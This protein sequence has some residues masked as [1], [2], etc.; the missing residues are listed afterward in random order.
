MSSASSADPSWHNLPLGDLSTELAE[1][2]F[3]A[4]RMAE[5][6]QSE[7]IEM[8]RSA[9]RSFSEREWRSALAMGISRKGASEESRF[10]AAVSAYRSAARGGVPHTTNVT[11][12]LIK[13]GTALVC[14]ARPVPK[15][16]ADGADWRRVE[17]A[18]KRTAWCNGVMRKE[19][20]HKKSLQA[21]QNGCTMGD[22]YLGVVRAF[23]EPDIKI[24]HWFTLDCVPDDE[25][26]CFYRVERVMHQRIARRYGD[27]RADQ[28]ECDDPDAV[29]PLV[30]G[31]FFNEKNADPDASCIGRYAVAAEGAPLLFEEY[32]H[33]GPP[34]VRWSWARDPVGLQ[35]C[36]IPW[37]VKGIQ[38]LINVID[39][40][41]HS[42]IWQGGQLRIFAHRL[43]KIDK[44]HISNSLRAQ[45]LEWSGDKPP[46]FAITP[47]VARDLTEFRQVL[48][49]AAYEMTGL[50]ISNA[51]ASPQ[52]AGESGRARLLEDKSESL[53]NIAPIRD[54]DDMMGVELP[55]KLLEAAADMQEQF[56][57]MQVLYQ[58]QAT[59]TPVRLKDLTVDLDGIDIDV[60]STS[61]LAS[62]A[63][64][65]IAQVDFMVERGYWNA[66]E[67]EPLM[68]DMNIGKQENLDR[69]ATRA[70][71]WLLDKV[72]RGGD[73]SKYGPTPD[74][75]F[76]RALRRVVQEI[77]RLTTMN[78]ADEEAL[79]RLRDWKMQ[80]LLL[81][82][83]DG[84]EATTTGFEELLAKHAQMLA[85]PPQPMPG[86]PGADL[87]LGAGGAVPPPGLD[88]GEVPPSLPVDPAAAAAVPPPAPLF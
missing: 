5:E 16:I 33:I 3:D 2:L 21:V 82:G 31:W 62:S 50:S 56:G 36:G 40:S 41:I 69:I 39:T 28:I 8:Q 87:G 44:S 77:L 81:H 15:F 48:I 1:K 7:R 26:C 70:V 6:N 53:T 46:E 49:A 85:P 32:K 14:R 23:W 9:L 12:N 57:D 24:E 47:A 11:R 61:A 17:E 71:E 59:V 45:I 67:A 58:N 51:Q 65:R 34:C 22:G 18:A 37:E 76:E 38:T 54:Y 83:F 66:E 10:N 64:A 60:L 19:A 13:S 79:D 35:G 20:A 42:G 29:I 30:H 86:L 78:S 55:R 27:K 84:E 43:A 4:I 25:H 80:L 72:V 52:F 75:P 88:G 63:G 68:L 73:V 74:L